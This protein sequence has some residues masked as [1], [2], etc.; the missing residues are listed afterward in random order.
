MGRREGEEH[1]KSGSICTSLIEG[2]RD[3]NLN[4][5]DGL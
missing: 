5:R 3:P 1:K 4:L 2:F